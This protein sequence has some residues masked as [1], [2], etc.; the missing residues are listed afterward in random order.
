M[1]IE[2]LRNEKSPFWPVDLCWLQ[3]REWPPKIV[4]LQNFCWILFHYVSTFWP[5]ISDTRDSR[6]QEAVM[7]QVFKTKNG[8]MSYLFPIRVCSWLDCHKSPC[9][10]KNQ[11]KTFFGWFP[12]VSGC[13][14]AETDLF[15]CCC[16]FHLFF[17]HWLRVIELWTPLPPQ[18]LSH[19]VPQTT[20][21]VYFTPLSFSTV[22]MQ[23][24]FP[25]WTFPQHIGA[26]PLGLQLFPALITH[27][28]HI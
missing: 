26:S 8:N 3:Y 19:T 1:K 15:S 5:L 7:T 9:L 18:F 13:C 25:I 21:L 20:P 11:N 24:H 27:L 17:F 4:G 2:E 14:F 16:T 28:G 6:Q 22:P 10:I 12:L 23:Q